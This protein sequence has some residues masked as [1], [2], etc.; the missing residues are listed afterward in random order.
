LFTIIDEAR[1]T[2]GSVTLLQTFWEGA[3]A[4]PDAAGC[5]EPIPEIPDDYVVPPNVRITADLQLA[6]DLVNSGLAFT[7]QGWSLKQQACTAGDLLNNRENGLMLVT[8]AQISF[9]SAETKLNQVL[10]AG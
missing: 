1:S 8:N 10:E 3:S 5:N 9:D 6:I 4:S 2:R 7:R